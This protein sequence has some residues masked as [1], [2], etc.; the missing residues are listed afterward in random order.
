MIRTQRHDPEVGVEPGVDDQRLQRRLR[1]PF[2]GRD[3]GDDLFQHQ[4]D[5]EAGLGG[6]AHR[7]HRVDADDVLDLLGNPL[8]LCGRQVD[9]V[10]HRHHFQ[11]H[12]HGGVAVGQSLCLNPLTGIH[13]QQ[14]PFTGSQGARNLVGE[15][16][17]ARGV[18][19]V[20]LIGVTVLCLV[21]QGHTLCL[22]G[23]A[24]LALQIHGVQHLGLHLAI[25][26]A[27]ASLDQTVRQ[28]RLTVVDVRNNRKVT[29]VF[30]GLFSHNR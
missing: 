23:N 22:D 21:V 3:L 26:Q 14:C 27:A 30:H 6:A 29:N 8:G 17:V 25:G 4:I 5:T 19:K 9:L 11:I 20:Q 28:G 18:D 1:I 16:H 13:H 24:A 12:F 10:Q 7:V 15:I 2:R